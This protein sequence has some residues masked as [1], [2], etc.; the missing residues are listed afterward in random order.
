MTC[1]ANLPRRRAAALDRLALKSPFC[2]TPLNLITR[3]KFPGFCLSDKS[4]TLVDAP[5]V[6]IRTLQNSIVFDCVLRFLRLLTT[7]DLVC[8]CTVALCS[9]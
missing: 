6:G 8:L 3:P 1:S 7:S 2:V 4:E 5:G 9:G